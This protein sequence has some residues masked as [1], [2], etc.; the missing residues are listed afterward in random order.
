[1]PWSALTIRLVPVFSPPGD[2]KSSVGSGARHPSPRRRP[3]PFSTPNEALTLSGSYL[4]GRRSTRA[5]PGVYW[6]RPFAT[7]LLGL[8]NRRESNQL[9]ALDIVMSSRCPYRIAFPICSNPMSRVSPTAARATTIINGCLPEYS[10]DGDE[11]CCPPALWLRTPLPT[12]RISRRVSRC[13]HCAPLST[14]C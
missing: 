9:S 3:L 1:M 7:L 5:L 11:G 8:W 14:R 2:Y 10:P 13:G 6:T 12:G 4:H